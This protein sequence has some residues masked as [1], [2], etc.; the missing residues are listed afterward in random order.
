M[1]SALAKRMQ[2]KTCFKFTSIDD[3]LLRELECVTRVGLAAF[4]SAGF[5]TS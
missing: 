2:G 1:S 4:E 5:I 3:T